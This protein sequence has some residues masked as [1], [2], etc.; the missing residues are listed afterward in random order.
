[1]TTLRDEDL[2]FSSDQAVSNKEQSNNS[3]K[4]Q[5]IHKDVEQEIQC[6]LVTT[7]EN[8]KEAPSQQPN[9]P[10]RPTQL[11]IHIASKNQSDVSEP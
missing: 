4:S 8:E 3:S 6:S 9:I 1:M 5:S 7:K 2:T 10:S 11:S